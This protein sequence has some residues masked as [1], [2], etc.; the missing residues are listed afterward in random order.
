MKVERSE[1]LLRAMASRQ[2]TSAGIIV[3][4][5]VLSNMALLAGS[6]FLRLLGGLVL[7]CFLPGF[8]LLAVLLPQ[9]GSAGFLE[10]ILLSAGTS[11]FLGTLVVLIIHFVP[12]PISLLSL[13]LGLDFL[14]ALLLVLCFGQRNLGWPTFN[15]PDRRSL[16]LIALVLFL[17]SFYRFG[18]L[19]HSEYQGDEIDV[20]SLAQAAISGQ[21]DAFF[22]HKKGPAEL[23]V[24][25]AFALFT[26]GFNEFAL[27]F[28][29]ALASTLAVLAAFLLASRMFNWRVAGLAGALLAIE[30]ITLGFS[31]MVQYHGVVVLALTLAFYCFY[32]LNQVDDSGLA[33]RYQ[34]LGAGFFAFSLLA[35]YEAA[36]MGLPLF[37]LYWQRY[38]R[39]FL[40]GRAKNWK[41]PAEVEKWPQALMHDGGTLFLSVGLVVIVLAA[42]YV[43]FVLHPH[44]AQTFESYTTI[45]IS[46]ERGPYNNLPDYFTSNI[47]YN[48]IYYVVTMTVFLMVASVESV[49]RGLRPKSLAIAILLLFVGGLMG[50]I[51]SPSLLTL[52]GVKYSLLLFLPF[53]ISLWLGSERRLS[54]VLSLSKGSRGRIETKRQGISAEPGEKKSLGFGTLPRWHYEATQP[55]LT[56]RRA[57]FLWFLSYLIFYAFII[58]VPGLHYYCL[59]PAWAILAAL[60]LERWIPNPPRAETPHARDRFAIRR[61]PRARWVL[62]YAATVVIYALSA[63]YAYVLFVRT[64]PEYALSYPQH[65]IPLYWNTHQERPLRFFGLPHKSGWKTIGTLYKVGILQGDY[66]TNEK[67]EVAGWYTGQEPSQAERPRYYFIA[68]NPTQKEHKQD[69]PRELLQREYQ[70]V[71][72]V[73]VGGRPRLHIYELKA[74]S[75]Q[76][77]ITHYESE[78]YEPL[79]DQVFALPK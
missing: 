35:H 70:V 32:R 74:S 26:N 73:T 22:W 39:P 64:E 45:R 59:S 46:P 23:A 47:F 38:G 68:E 10:R 12:G 25:T 5:T 18:A 13:L 4:L 27:R 2:I 17:A 77:E 62:T 72:T 53:F 14:I 61:S 63:F 58:R 67:S 49:W 42:Y 11:Y 54:A 8:L 15:L 69:Y 71:G 20:T 7:F 43:P 50:S 57:V 56:E 52:G 48:S 60:G 65:R 41:S 66:C 31:R 19:G 37:F 16:A 21:D 3:A 24:A 30:G 36:L 55:A 28:P 76:G 79:Y 75:A 33:A 29:F 44:F 1:H 9:P 40:K 78:A 51:L 6:P 34:L